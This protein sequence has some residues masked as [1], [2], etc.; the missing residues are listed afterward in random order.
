MSEFVSR[1][2]DINSPEKERIKDVAYVWE[3]EIPK[4]T[5][6]SLD[7]LFLMWSAALRLIESMKESETT[8]TVDDT[9]P[10][11]WTIAPDIFHPEFADTVDLE[12]APQPSPEDFYTYL[13]NETYYLGYIEECPGRYYL[14]GDTY[15]GGVENLKRGL[16]HGQWMNHITSLCSENGEPYFDV[17]NL[18]QEDIIS[19]ML[20]LDV[21]EDR[22]IKYADNMMMRSL[23]LKS[24]AHKKRAAFKCRDAIRSYKKRSDVGKLL[25]RFDARG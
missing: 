21:D 6:Y 5:G 17:D 8:E 3:F 9:I 18:S 16:L 2:L 12:I 24:E 1:S 15:K 20:P 23:V 19:I 22:L 4:P 10:P 13:I 11:H 25:L 7:K 14:L